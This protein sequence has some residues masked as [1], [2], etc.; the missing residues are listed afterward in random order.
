MLQG[1]EAVLSVIAS[2]LY[3]LSSR[4]LG[5]LLYWQLLSVDSLGQLAFSEE[6]GN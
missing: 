2:W 6:I 1:S 3:G 4:A 5:Q